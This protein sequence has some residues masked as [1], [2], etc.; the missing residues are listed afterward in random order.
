M[1]ILVPVDFS[2]TAQNAFLYAV[3]LAEQLHASILLL[4]TYNVDFGLPMPGAAVYQIQEERRKIANE[5]IDKWLKMVEG[6]KVQIDRAVEN[7]IPWDVIHHVAKKEAADAIVMGTKGE[8]NAA[9]VFFGSVTTHVLSSAPCPVWVVP[10]GVSFVAAPKI[11]YAIEINQNTPDTITSILE[12]ARALGGSL[13]CV[14][15]NTDSADDAFE[16]STIEELIQMRDNTVSIDFHQ[17]ANSSV[18][19][20]LEQFVSEHNIGLLALLRPQRSF[21]ER[22]FHRSQTRKIALNANVA[23]FVFH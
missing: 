11:A 1:K 23:L 12:T 13:H 4:H 22:I 15:V 17:I 7:G 8:H 5:T 20:G 6:R 9:E 2:A 3:S 19:E 18:S 14:H 10:E 21:F 16:Q